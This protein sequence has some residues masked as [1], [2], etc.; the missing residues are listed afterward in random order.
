[1]V[2]VSLGSYLV[3][4]VSWPSLLVRQVSRSILLLQLLASAKLLQPISNR[5]YSP[6]PV[7]AVNMIFIV[8]TV[9]AEG[10]LVEVQAREGASRDEAAVD[11][12]GRVLSERKGGERGDGNCHGAKDCEHVVC[13]G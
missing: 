5:G 11:K 4:G 13:R 7:V 6:S 9:H 12:A 8:E 3:M 10:G 1:M 2:G